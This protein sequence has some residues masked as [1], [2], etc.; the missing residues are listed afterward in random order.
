MVPQNEEEQLAAAWRALSGKAEGQGWKAIEILSGL[1][2]VV[3]AGR[4]G[5]GNEESLLIGIV[6]VAAPSDLHLPQGRGFLFTRTDQLEDASGRTWFSLTRRAGGQLP[7]FTLMAADLVSLLAG[8]GS[9]AG[10][11]I[12]ALLI[13]RIRGWQ[14]FMKRDRSGVLSAE[15]EVGLV[16]ELM[17]LKD[18]MVAGISAP[19]A[20]E[21]WVGPEDGIHDFS[22]GNGGVEAKATLAPIGFIAEIGSLDQLDDSLY[23]PLFVAAVRLSQSTSGKTLPEIVDEIVEDTRES[24][25]TQLLEGRLLSAGYVGSMREYYARRFAMKELSYRQVGESSPRLTRSNVPSAIQRVKYALDLDTIPVVAS[26][27]SEISQRFGMSS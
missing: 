16:G 9:K 6:G 25:I 4:R 15:E 13:A 18:L 1:R 27:F 21:S 20:V 17:V 3:M 24:G 19:D 26:R 2:C 7:I 5:G 22:I 8:I 12:Y 14:E 23:Q 11:D 10:R